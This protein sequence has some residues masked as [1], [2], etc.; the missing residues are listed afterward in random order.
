M[1]EIF[2]YLEISQR[3]QSNH[4][5]HTKIANRHKTISKILTTEYI[6]RKIYTIIF[7]THISKAKKNIKTENDDAGH[8]L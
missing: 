2:P 3:I 4:I 1:N 5:T 7:V 8:H 6:R